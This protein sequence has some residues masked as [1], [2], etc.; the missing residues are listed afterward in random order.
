MTAKLQASQIWQQMLSGRWYQTHAKPL[1]RARQHAKAQCDTLNT[2]LTEQQRLAV[3]AQLMPL[4]QLNAIGAGFYCDYG[5]NITSGEGLS[6]GR[7][8]V[9]LDAAKIICGHH[10]T[11]HD[12]A[13]I[14]TVNHATDP[15]RRQAGWQQAV[16]IVIGDNVTIE[17]GATVLPGAIIPSNTRLPAH[18][19]FTKTN[20]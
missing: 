7:N 16:G 9:M 12:G 19:V 13:V 4:I 20:P 3:A 14:A 2:A 17:S 15:Q 6:V 8:V 11:I 5:L 1:R 18:S 10:V